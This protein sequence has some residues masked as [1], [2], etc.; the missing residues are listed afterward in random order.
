M[1]RLQSLVGQ[2]GSHVGCSHADRTAGG[3]SDGVTALE[4]AEGGPSPFAL[5]ALVVDV[6]SHAP[7][8]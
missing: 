7:A 6:A 2:L 3:T 5:W 8:S 4:G 1:T